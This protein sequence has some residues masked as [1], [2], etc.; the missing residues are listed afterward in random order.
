VRKAFFLVAIVLV[1][2][3]CS[4][5]TDRTS[6]VGSAAKE[7]VSN[8]KYASLLVEIDYPTGYEPNADALAAFKEALTQV[9]GRDAAHILFAQDPSI[10]AETNRAYSYND[11]QALENAHRD[12]HSG[13]DT[14][15]LYIVYVAGSSEKDTSDGKV[16]G[17]AYHGTSIVIFKGNIKANT[18][19]GGLST[20]PQEQ[21]VERAV[22]IHEFGHAAG[23]VN[24]GAP[25]VRDHEDRMDDPAGRGHS[26]NPNSVMYW[27]VENTAGLASIV[28]CV[29]GACGADIPHQFDADD[30][31]DLQALRGR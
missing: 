22:L 24:L 23:L 17:A 15:A 12:K 25:M 14:A 31:A 30:K 26:T 5:I 27:K 4:T 21:Y 11:I 10:P 6:S 3:G 1:T 16:L 2:A 20:K 19:G 13:G 8:A 7:L 29:T 28:N 9:S 18:G